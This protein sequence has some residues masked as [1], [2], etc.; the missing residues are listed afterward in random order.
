M[1]RLLYALLTLTALGLALSSAW[2]QPPAA[3][4]ALL[5]CCPGENR[6]EYAGY[7]YMR[8]LTDAG[9]AVDYLEGSAEL[10]WDRVKNYNVLFIYD[11]P[12]PGPESD[13][14][15]SLF[16]LQPPWVE[17]YFGVLDRFLKAG[18]GLFL[19]YCPSYGAAAPNQLLKAWGIQF[20]LIW[21][22]HP[23]THTMTNMPVP[24][25]YTDRILPSAWTSRAAPMSLCM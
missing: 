11:F 7:D 16:A 14:S 23:E 8:A 9:F 22:R 19:H 1:N 20:P 17:D 3:K 12:P 10:T 6:Y 4:P 5:F 2:A 13:P 24:L 18:G 15:Y 21:L 25:A